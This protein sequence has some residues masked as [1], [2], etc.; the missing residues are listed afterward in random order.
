[1][2]E[3]VEQ[4]I[5]SQNICSYGISTFII[6]NIVTH[7]KWKIYSIS[8]NLPQ[9]CE[10]GVLSHSGAN[11]LFPLTIISNDKSNKNTDG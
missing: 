3:K 11:T 7:G 2:A 1:M 5:Y 10:K 6:R 8:E 9:Y 4:A